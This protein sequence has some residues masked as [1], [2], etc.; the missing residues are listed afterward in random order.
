MEV[1][2]SLLLDLILF[3]FLLIRP[4]TALTLFFFH[5]EEAVTGIYVIP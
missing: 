1:F 5:L 3:I 2:L 4:S